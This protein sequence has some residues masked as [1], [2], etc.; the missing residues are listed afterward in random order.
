MIFYDFY[1]DGK[2][3]IDKRNANVRQFSPKII[4]LRKWAIQGFQNNIKGWGDSP[5]W[6][7]EE[8]LLSDVVIIDIVVKGHHSP[9]FFK[10][11][12]FLDSPSWGN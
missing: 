8:I 7:E 2:Q 12:R 10:I 6:R 5:S 9:P 1:H 3:Q 4:F 11:H